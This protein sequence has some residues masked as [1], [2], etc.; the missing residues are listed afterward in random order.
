MAPLAECKP[1]TYDP[2]PPYT[3]FIPPPT[4][5]D[6]FLVAHE[7]ESTTMSGS[8]LTKWYPINW[9]AQDYFIHHD[10]LSGGDE[11]DTNLFEDAVSEQPI[12]T[13]TTYVQIGRAS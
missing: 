9:D 12:M 3:S 1:I 10:P 6:G 5:F 13:N 4:S 8:D 2:L 7:R 11:T